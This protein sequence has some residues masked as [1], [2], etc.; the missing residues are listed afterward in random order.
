LSQ[1]LPGGGPEAVEAAH[2]LAR[3][4]I[5]QQQPAEDEG[6]LASDEALQA[7]REKLTGN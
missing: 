2:W 3:I 4:A 5:K 7:L 6:T 1:V